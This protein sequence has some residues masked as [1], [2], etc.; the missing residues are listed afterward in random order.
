MGVMVVM[1]GIQ[2]K[3]AQD[4]DGEPLGLIIKGSDRW[5]TRE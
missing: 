5:D 3:K 4:G 2:E 1:M